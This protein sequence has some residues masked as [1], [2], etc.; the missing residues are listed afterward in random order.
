MHNRKINKF[1]LDRRKELDEL[2]QSLEYSIN[3][4]DHISAVESVRKISSMYGIK[5]NRKSFQEFNNLID[6]DEY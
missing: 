4:S 3:N 2:V 5:S 6:E 1:F